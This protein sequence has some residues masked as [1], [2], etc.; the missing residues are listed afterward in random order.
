LPL[1]PKATGTVSN[2]ESEFSDELIPCAD[3]WLDDLGSFGQTCWEGMYADPPADPCERAI[4]QLTALVLNVCSER[5][6][7]T[8]ELDLSS[9]SCSAVSVVGLLDELAD[10]IFD[11][12]C[13]LAADC[14]ALVNEGEGLLFGDDF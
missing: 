11:E 13:E 2:K 3:Q 5:L 12:D 8:C 7:L 4:S 6:Y 10:L 14:A 9:V 1:R